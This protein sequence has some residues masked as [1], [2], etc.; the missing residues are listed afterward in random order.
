MVTGMR[1]QHFREVTPRLGI[2]SFPGK[3]SAVKRDGVAVAR[4]H[5]EM[6]FEQLQRFGPVKLI[7][8]PGAAYDIAGLERTS[9]GCARR[10]NVRQKRRGT[11]K[12]IV[13]PDSGGAP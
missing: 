13:T 3:Q 7:H 11:P 8:R 9:Q 10:Q 4:L 6:F 5:C 12:R 2:A 1:R